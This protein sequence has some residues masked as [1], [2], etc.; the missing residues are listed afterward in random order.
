[1]AARSLIRTGEFLLVI[2]ADPTSGVALV[3]A[4]TWTV[5]GGPIERSWFYQCDLQGPLSIT[6]VTHRGPSPRVRG[7]PPRLCF[8][9]VSSSRLGGSFGSLSWLCG[10]ESQRQTGHSDSP[11]GC[12]QGP[13]LTEIV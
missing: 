6:I 9:K 11:C 12:V 4:G 5:I 3:P 7:K 1:M 8:V 13:I 10:T 2:E